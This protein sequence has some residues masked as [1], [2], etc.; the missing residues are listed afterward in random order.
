MNSCDLLLVQMIFRNILL[1]RS[2]PSGG[3]GVKVQNEKY[4]GLKHVVLF[5]Y[6]LKF[7]ICY[8]FQV[9]RHELCNLE[10]FRKCKRNVNDVNYDNWEI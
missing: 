6:F 8:F 5:T 4:Y 10:K 7:F 9:L 1:R 3:R 2:R